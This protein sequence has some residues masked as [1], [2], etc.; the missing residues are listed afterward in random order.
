MKTKNF[1]K[2]LEKRL[3]KK[4]IRLIEKQA[5]RELEIF[6]LLQNFVA[7]VIN[8]YMEKNDIGFNELARQLDWSPSKVSKTRRG[9]GNL[10]LSSL[11]HLFALTGDDPQ[12]FIPIKK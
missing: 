4:E 3:D 8:V 1:E 9:E 10:T 7:E 5:K 6:Q 11:A 2:Y 12:S